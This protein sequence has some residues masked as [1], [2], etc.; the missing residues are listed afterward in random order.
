MISMP[1]LTNH[2][3]DRW[4]P[5][6]DCKSCSAPPGNDDP[7]DG[8]VNADGAVWGEGGWHL[9][10]IESPVGIGAGAAHPAF[11]AQCSCRWS[12]P[13]RIKH[14]VERGKGATVAVSPELEATEDGQ[15]HAWAVSH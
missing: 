13:T 6:C 2:H 12:G 14:S 9:V 4:W 1:H 7:V 11:Y 5:G 10:T 3:P 8:Y 15:R